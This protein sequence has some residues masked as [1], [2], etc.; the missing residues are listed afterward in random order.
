M[1]I[2]TKQFNITVQELRQLITRIY[3]QQRRIIL[4]FYAV[5]TVLSF[6]TA[7]DDFSRTLSICLV[8][9]FIYS[10]DSALYH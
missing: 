10:D 8:I 2:K 6:F 3:Y 5:T 9:S 1:V 7:I 4:L